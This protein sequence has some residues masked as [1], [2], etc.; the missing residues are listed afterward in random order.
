MMR[1]FSSRISGWLRRPH[2]SSEDMRAI[3]LVVLL[4]TVVSGQLHEII[5]GPVVSHTAGFLRDRIMPKV[6]DETFRLMPVVFAWM[7]EHDDGKNVVVKPFVGISP[8]FIHWDTTNDVPP[9]GFQCDR[10]SRGAGDGLDGESERVQREHAVYPMRVLAT[11]AGEARSIVSTLLDNRNRINV[12]VRR[13]IWPWRPR[14]TVCSFF[15]EANKES[16]R[17]EVGALESKWFDSTAG[18]LIED[19]AGQ[20]VGKWERVHGM[21]TVRG[22]RVYS[23]G[24]RID[25]GLKRVCSRLTKAMKKRVA[26]ARAGRQVYNCASLKLGLGLFLTGKPPKEK[27]SQLVTRLEVVDETSDS[28]D[29][30]ARLA[31]ALWS[32]SSGYERARLSAIILAEI[33]ALELVA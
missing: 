7:E 8:N 28:P 10:E 21:E 24:K 33:K 32:E 19:V 20:L 29:K 16:A 3:A 30:A 22:E 15:F 31:H 2:H 6:D 12:T 18:S 9:H 25:M 4:A 27:R 14:N 17:E 5:L 1:R 11:S 23:P 26:V 13:R